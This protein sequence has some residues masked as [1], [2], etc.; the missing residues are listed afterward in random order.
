ME[1]ISAVL[2]ENPI[3]YAS[4]THRDFH[5]PPPPN[6]VFPYFTTYKKVY[7]ISTAS[8]APETSPEKT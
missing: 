8:P 7:T 5:K 3:K 1:C 4:N 6:D 2:Y